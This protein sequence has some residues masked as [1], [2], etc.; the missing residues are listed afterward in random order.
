MPQAQHEIR[1]GDL[2]EKVAT[3]LGI[4]KCGGCERRRQLLNKI[5]VA[6]LSNDRGLLLRL[7][8]GMGL[9]ALLALACLAPGCKAFGEAVQAV[10][11]GKVGAEI[12]RTSLALTI[13]H[14]TKVADAINK[15]APGAPATGEIV[16][17]V[18]ETV[19]SLIKAA[20]A[21]LPKPAP[22]PVPDRPGPAPGVGW[23]TTI[24]AALYAANQYRKSRAILGGGAPTPHT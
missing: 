2:V 18:A 24:L 7:A 5:L 11:W 3:R 16:K 9:L 20:V 23:D 21:D 6:R 8:R 4:E 1:L 12:A 10:D 14:N 22:Q 15:I 17:G 19:G 13:E